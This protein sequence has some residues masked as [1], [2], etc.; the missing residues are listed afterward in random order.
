[1][2]FPCL[3]AKTTCNFNGFMLKSTPWSVEL[4]EGEKVGK[5]RFQGFPF[6]ADQKNSNSLRYSYLGLQAA[7]W[8]VVCLF[9]LHC[10]SK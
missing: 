1:M 9:F 8:G 10:C 6:L 5:R 7:P 4:Y 2:N 3:E